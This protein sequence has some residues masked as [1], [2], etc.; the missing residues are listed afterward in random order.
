[1]IF[2]VNPTIERFSMRKHTFQFHSRVQDTCR[3]DSDAFSCLWCRCLEFLLQSGATASLEDKQGYRPIHYA[4]AY[5]HKHCLE[6]VRTHTHTHTFF[7]DYTPQDIIFI[8]INTFFTHA[9]R[10]LTL[11]SLFFFFFKPF[12]FKSS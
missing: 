3:P 12:Y 8:L 6:L 7:Q 11:C 1:M 4:A 9:N 10:S 2:H 5:G